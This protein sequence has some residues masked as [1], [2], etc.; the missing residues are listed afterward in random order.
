[1]H[2]Q[3]KLIHERRDRKMEPFYWIL[4]FEGLSLLLL[5][6]LSLIAFPA[7]WALLYQGWAY[8]LLLLTALGLWLLRISI[9]LLI[10]YIWDNNHLNTYKLYEDRIEWVEYNK[11]TRGKRED[12]TPLRQITEAYIGRYLAMYHYAYKK[13]N[14]REKQALYHLLPSLHIVY[15]RGDELETFEIPFYEPKDME[16]WLAA[17]QEAGV[18]VQV[19]TAIMGGGMNTEQ[20][21]IA[22]ANPDNIWPYE[23]VGLFSEAYHQLVIRMDEQAR[24]KEMGGGTPDEPT[25]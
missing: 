11:K 14:W 25:A 3:P 23:E 9:K 7:Y 5:L 16:P 21:L 22:L 20:R 4:T 6:A 15:R 17:L 1:M 24:Q 12:I 2:V 8:T 18:F 10:K 13:S 19:F